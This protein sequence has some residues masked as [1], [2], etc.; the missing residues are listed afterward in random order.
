MPT[1]TRKER[2]HR[3]MRERSFISKLAPN[4]HRLFKEY[5]EPLKQEYLNGR[6]YAPEDVIVVAPPTFSPH[7]SDFILHL[8][9]PHLANIVTFVVAKD[10]ESADPASLLIL[11]P[12]GV[13][14]SYS[15]SSLCATQTDIT[16]SSLLFYFINPRNSYPILTLSS[17]A[18]PV[19]MLPF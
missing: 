1:E 3:H 8:A 18:N 5:T 14:F 10:D 7:L 17:N 19:S 15:S 4:Q 2:K 6:W 12:Q 9:E 13:T 11:E 16:I